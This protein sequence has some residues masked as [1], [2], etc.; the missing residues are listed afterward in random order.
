[1][2]LR[3]HGCC[4]LTVQLRSKSAKT[5]LNQ[6]QIIIMKAMTVGK[7]VAVV[8]V[9]VCVL[10]ASARA[11]TIYELGSVDPGSPAGPLSVETGYASSLV[12][13]YNAG[14][15]SW[16]ASG[17]IYTI[18]KGSFVPA[19]LL[20]AVGFNNGQVNGSGLITQSINLCAGGDSYA[21]GHWAGVL[22]IFL[23]FCQNRTH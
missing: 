6:K 21:P 2:S 3:R 9:G 1:M 17:Y 20:P 14:L 8:A 19:P 4:L 7:I 23:H 18:N 10:A 5:T 16:T 12:T 11:N 15:T 13:G 22:R